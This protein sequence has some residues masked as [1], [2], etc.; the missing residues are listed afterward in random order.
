MTTPQTRERSR[1]M[2]LG[3][4]VA[5]AAT[6]GLHWVYDQPHIVKIAPEAPEFIT[7]T[8][9]NY[10]G[11]LGYFAHATRSTGM[12]SQYGEQAMVMLRTLAEGGNGSTDFADQFRAY[13]GYGGG[14]VGYI[15]HATRDTMDNLR[16]YEDAAHH[17]AEQLEPPLERRLRKQLVAAALP[18]L[19]RYEGEE[20]SQRY[21]A[22]V[23]GDL[24][25]AAKTLLPALLRIPRPTGSYD[26]QLPAIAKLPP[27]V[28]TMAVQEDDIFDAEIDAAVRTTSDHPTAR[29][30]GAISG[31]MM[32][33]ALNEGTIEAVIRAAE[34]TAQGDAAT[35][36]AQALA[37]R[38]KG[39]AE[40]T[41]HFGMACDLPY[42]LPSALH[43]IATAADYTTAV[44]RNIYAGGDNCGRAILVG[45]IMGA[46]HG[47]P[48]GWQMQMTH[49]QEADALIDRLLA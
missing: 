12:Q 7:P 20:L 10:E 6:M 4:L 35:L 21:E 42:G 39:N 3:A 49:K 2:I 1:N 47:V 30:Y 22:A 23:D 48:E 17:A 38:D 34:Q 5:D 29:H 40:V 9:S 8:A 26:L 32:R 44:R 43:N 19:A 15:D 33:A 45:A 36:V 37:M 24:L 27:L 28:A 13:F 41:R 46:L 14:Y 25:P 18:L 11:V 31:R 16:R